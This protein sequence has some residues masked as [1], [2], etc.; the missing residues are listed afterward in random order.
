MKNDGCCHIVA[1]YD[2]QTQKLE[3]EGVISWA[4]F[5]W[6]FLMGFRKNEELSILNK[7]RFKKLTQLFKALTY[8][9]RNKT[10]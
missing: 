2:I 6:R 4:L 7:Y 3:V 1:K 8:E 10:D 5:S 9:M